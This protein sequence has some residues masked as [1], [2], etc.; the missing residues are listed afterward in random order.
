M[1]WALRSPRRQQVNPHPLNCENQGTDGKVLIY[2]ITEI[3]NPSFSGF[4]A[5]A[6]GDVKAEIAAGTQHVLQMIRCLPA[7]QASFE[8]LWIY[9]P[10]GEGGHSQGRL[11][12]YVRA[13]PRTR[14]WPR[15]WHRSWNEACSALSMSCGR[16][17]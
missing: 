11:R 4:R 17:N 3:P 5:A 15:C 7:G 2:R 8:I 10:Q 14:P 13:S 16:S 9:T 1:A 12:I 6:G